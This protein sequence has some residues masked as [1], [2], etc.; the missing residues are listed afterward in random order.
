[1]K[2]KKIKIAAV[3]ASLSGV[4]SAGI[5]GAGTIV[6]EIITSSEEG[7]PGH[8]HAE[9]SVATFLFGDKS[10]KKGSRKFAVDKNGSSVVNKL[11]DFYS[12]TEL[13]GEKTPLDFTDQQSWSGEFTGMKYTKHTKDAYYISA[14]FSFFQGSFK[15]DVYNIKD[16]TITWST[17]D[18]NSVNPTLDFVVRASDFTVVAEST[19]KLEVLGQWWSNLGG[20][21]ESFTYNL[22]DSNH[23]APFLYHF[24]RTTAYFKEYKL[25]LNFRLPGTNFAA[26]K[27][28]YKQLVDG[29]NAD[30]SNLGWDYGTTTNLTLELLMNLFT[31]GYDLSTPFTAWGEAAFAT[32]LGWEKDRYVSEETA[33]N[34]IGTY[35]ETT[36]TASL[37]NVDVFKTMGEKIPKG[38]KN[39]YIGYDRYNRDSILNFHF[40]GDNLFVKEQNLS[41]EYLYAISGVK[42]TVLPF[43]SIILFN[44]W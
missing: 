43:E 11:F 31:S 5:G 29:D 1:M 10:L 12:T 33:V 6:S 36:Q 7:L 9:E 32:N 25:D 42:V 22:T 44:P 39:E 3:V 14:N 34:L 30:T 8:W 4:G 27:K 26:N 38:L 37:Q 35:N 19:S 20:D 41:Y 40:Q 28:D 21:Q 18:F 13:Y 16:K 23:E 2:I 17:S 24:H 15:S